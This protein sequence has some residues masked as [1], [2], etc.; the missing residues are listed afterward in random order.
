MAHLFDHDWDPSG[1]ASDGGEPNGEFR[2]DIAEY[3]LDHVIEQRDR[4]V[5]YYEDID[6]N[7]N[8]SRD[9]LYQILQKYAGTRDPSL[10]GV[11]RSR[12]MISEMGPKL[13][14][15]STSSLEDITPVGAD[16]STA[17]FSDRLGL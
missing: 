3:L 13:D 8:V 10:H 2:E 9:T 12:Q 16:V 7:E 11:R 6:Y 4:F 5:S 15:D 1:F 14:D 17:D